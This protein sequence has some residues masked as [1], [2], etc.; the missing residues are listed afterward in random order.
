MISVPNLLLSFATWLVWSMIVAK[1]QK[2]HDKDPTVYDFG[3]HDRLQ[4]AVQSGLHLY[5]MALCC[6]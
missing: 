6:S 5:P 4:Q 3:E 1:I 2:L